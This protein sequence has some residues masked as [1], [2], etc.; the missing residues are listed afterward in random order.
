MERFLLLR[1][2]HFF[3][4]LRLFPTRTR[5][6]LIRMVEQSFLLF[7]CP[8]YDFLHERGIAK[9][10]LMRL[11]GINHRAPT[12]VLS[13]FAWKRPMISFELQSNL[14]AESHS[15]F[16]VLLR[17]YTRSPYWTESE[18]HLPMSRWALLRM[19]LAHFC[20][21]MG[22]PRQFSRQMHTYT[23]FLHIPILY[24]CPYMY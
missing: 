2:L 24:I 4:L 10:F 15:P 11:F 13:D 19:I 21:Y 17:F 23:I 22:A 9:S 7:L 16:S 6:A 12:S 20:F 14:T 18:V 3:S 8:V 1:G 5:A